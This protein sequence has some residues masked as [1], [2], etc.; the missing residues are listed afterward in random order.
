MKICSLYSLDSSIYIDIRKIK[1]TKRSFARHRGLP[2]S[3]RWA[4]NLTPVHLAEWSDGEIIRAIREGVGRDGRSL[5]VMP[6]AY[7]RNMS[8]EDVLA[9]VAYLRSQSAVE[10]ASPP[11]QINVLGAIMLAALFPPEFFSVQ[12]PLAAPVAAP[13][14]GPTA[15]YGGYL[16]SLECQGCHGGD[17]WTISTRFY[18]PDTA[19]TAALLST[20]WTAPSG[21]PA[22]LLPAEDQRF[23]RFQ[24]ANAGAFDQVQ[25]I[26][27][28]VDTFGKADAVVGSMPELR[29]DMTTTGQGNETN[30]KGF[31]P[32]SLLGL[33]SGAP[34]LHGGGA[35]SLE[36]LFSSTFLAHYGTLAPNF[37]AEADP[38]ERAKRVDELVQFLLSIDAE[39]TPIASPVT[40]G[41]RGGSFCA[42]P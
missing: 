13:P 32:P 34:Y 16:V 6:S 17:K 21:F 35:T 3:S 8:D 23:M 24:G 29:Q 11:R 38:A 40:P 5:L 22:S 41:A 4:P 10:P 31:N 39:Q 9:L 26:L 30:G 2:S 33:Q 12:P 18:T 7:F 37:L 25:C 42:A 20:A 36:S 28:P 1:N 15:A 14:R 19:T 27:R